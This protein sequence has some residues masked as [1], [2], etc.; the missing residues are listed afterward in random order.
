MCRHGIRSSFIA[1]SNCRGLLTCLFLILF[2]ISDIVCYPLRKGSRVSAMKH[3]RILSDPSFIKKGIKMICNCNPLRKVQGTFPVCVAISVVLIALLAACPMPEPE[4]EPNM[5]GGNVSPPAQMAAPSLEAGNTQLRA[6]W[7]PPT[8]TGSSEITAYHVQHR[9][10][11]A[12]TWSTTDT[13]NIATITPPDASYTITGLTNGTSYDVRVRAVNAIGTGGWS[14]SATEMPTI[15][16]STQTPAGTAATVSLSADIDT[17]IAAQNPT[18]SLTT[19][20]PGTLAI[21]ASGV[22]TITPAT[23]PAG[24]TVPTVDAGTGVVTVTTSTTAGTYLVYGTESGGANILFAEF[25]SVTVSPADNTE[26][27]T[28]VNT[29]IQLWGDTADLNYI[30]TTAVT[31]MTEVFSSVFNGDISRWN[32]SSVTNMFYMFKSASAFNGDISDWDVSSVTS[33]FGMFNEAHAFN[34]N[35]SSWDVSSVT[36]MSYMFRE[37]RAF[38]SDISGWN[39][40]KVMNMAVMFNEARAFNGDISKWKTGAVTSMTSMFNSASAFNQNISS[41]DVSSVT[42]MNHMFDNASAFNGDI[43][44]WNVSKV[45]SMSYMFR[46]ASA[47]NGDISEWNV[48][49]VTSMSYMF[50]AASAFNQ[51]LEDWKDH[52]SPETGNKL[53]ASGKYTGNTTDMFVNSGV[54]TGMGQTA[55]PSWYQ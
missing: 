42:T 52:W 41:W 50:R 28:A 12:S 11:A 30:I 44:E 20:E 37:A 32:V 14:E 53:N 4:P 31:N 1:R 8:D 5:G 25:F 39:V 29:G 55:F 47:F 43:S 26:L 33:M 38:N 17:I 13:D 22:I 21:S 35:I 7:T 24:V 51:D 48:S 54:G 16:L 45:T 15:I 36:D 23:A 10:S 6:T 27:Q 46:A 18:V 9:T 3:K 19:V 2:D 40:S 34:Q 49:K